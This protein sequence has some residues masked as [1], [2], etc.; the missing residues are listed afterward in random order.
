MAA[1][2]AA[3]HYPLQAHLYLVALHRYLRWRLPDYR[4]EQH[5]GG[6][7]YVF[8]RGVPGP[9]PPTATGTATGGDVPGMFLEQPP[10]AR[11]LQLDRALGGPP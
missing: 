1:L 2:M 7:V 10:L 4:P 6:Y 3:N 9:L 11:L 8:L 5:L